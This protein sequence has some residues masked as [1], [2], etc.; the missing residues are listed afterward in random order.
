MVFRC[1]DHL[2]KKFILEDVP[3]G[4]S[5]DY[6]RDYGDFVKLIKSKKQI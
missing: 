1:I 5:D 2:G 3:A 4:D 6:I